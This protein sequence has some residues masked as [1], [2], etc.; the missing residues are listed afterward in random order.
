MSKIKTDFSW[1]CGQCGMTSRK[2]PNR[3]LEEHMNAVHAMAWSDEKNTYVIE[4]H[5]GQMVQRL[6]GAE[7]SICAIEAHI[8]MIK[9]F[10][11]DSDCDKMSELKETLIEYKTANSRVWQA[12]KAVFPIGKKVSVTQDLRSLMGRVESYIADAPDRLVISFAKQ[13]TAVVFLSQIRHASTGESD[14][15]R[16]KKTRRS[17]EEKIHASRKDGRQVEHISSD[18]P[19]GIYRGGADD[20]RT[21]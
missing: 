3:K 17:D 14:E 21:C 5:F 7:K 1:K 8:A 20:Q 2:E 12:L 9:Q 19:S 15:N 18:R 6:P 11:R 10:V 4:K 13:P 16:R